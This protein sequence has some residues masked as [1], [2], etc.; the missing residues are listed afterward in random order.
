MYTQLTEDGKYRFVSLHGR[1]GTLQMTAFNSKTSLRVC[2]VLEQA[3]LTGRRVRI[4]YGDKAG[5]DWMEEYDVIGYIGRST[6]KYKIPLIIH[7]DRS[8]GGPGLLDHCIVKIMDT[9]TK[10]VLYEAPNYQAPDLTLGEPPEVIGKVSMAEAGYTVG[11]Y[12]DG[13]N[14]ANFRTRKQAETWAAFMRGERMNW[15]R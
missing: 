6:G 2:E 13:E 14:V 8:T 9:R 1:L 15:G 10:Q 3:R 7:N 5:R 12:R 11:V 4:F